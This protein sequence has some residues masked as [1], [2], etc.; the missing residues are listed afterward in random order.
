MGFRNGEKKGKN[1]K[2]D[3]NETEI[4]AMEAFFRGNGE[5][6]H[7]LQDA[8]LSEIKATRK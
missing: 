3:C 6:G 1:M 7:A 4:R 2:I 8:F 5:G